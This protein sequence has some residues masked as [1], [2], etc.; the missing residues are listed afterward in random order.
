MSVVDVSVI[1][2]CTR[3]ERLL[4]VINIIISDNA[5]ATVSR[6]VYEY[7]SLLAVWPFESLIPLESFAYYMA[8]R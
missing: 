3:G 2:A 6:T 7:H 4:R 1:R 8:H 5:G